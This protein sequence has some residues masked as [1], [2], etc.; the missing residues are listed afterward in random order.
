MSI[1]TEVRALTDK[2]AKIDLSASSKGWGRDAR[3]VEPTSAPWPR[4]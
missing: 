1:P 4:N 3:P 2:N